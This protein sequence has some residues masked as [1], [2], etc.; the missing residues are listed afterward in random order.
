MNEKTNVDHPPIE[1]SNA[2]SENMAPT[3]TPPSDPWAEQKRQ[4][5]ELLKEICAEHHEQATGNAS[6]DSATFTD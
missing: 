3:T 1:P 2:T 5:I 4:D 6:A